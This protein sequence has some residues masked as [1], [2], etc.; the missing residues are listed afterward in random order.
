M[1]GTL[2]GIPLGFVVFLATDHYVTQWDIVGDRFAIDALGVCLGLCAYFAVRGIDVWL[3]EKKDNP[4]PFEAAKTVPEVFGTIKELLSEA[5]Y[6]PWSWNIKTVD[7]DDTRIMG[8]LKFTEMFG[9]GVLVPPTQAERMIKLQVLVDPIPEA[10]QKPQ[11]YVLPDLPKLQTRIQLT[12]RVDS[13]MGR[14]SVNKI[15]DDTTY[16]IKE[17]LGLVPGEKPQPK[18]PFEPPAWVVALTVL[19]FFF[20]FTRAE[21]Y[22]EY[23]KRTEEERKA[24]Q[25]QIERER[26]DR[27]EAAR[28]AAEEEAKRDAYNKEMADKFR[29][30]QEEQ[31]RKAQELLEEERRRQGGVYTPPY[32]TPYTPTPN[33]FAPQPDQGGSYFAPK[34]YTNPFTAPLSPGTSDQSDGTTSTPWRSRYG[35]SQ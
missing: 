33:P 10:E 32:T 34:R 22:Q 26:A 28:K 19:A 1:W 27:A 21:Q 3:N 24:R 14:V 2:L 23:K 16:A 17:T 8:I 31:R 20:C 7:P 29:Q 30:A 4:P 13:P 9:T 25:E 12:W 35:G 6:G 18:S 15:I 5:T 11:S